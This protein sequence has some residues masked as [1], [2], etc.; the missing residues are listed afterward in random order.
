MRAFVTFNHL[1]SHPLPED[2]AELRA[3]IQ[4]LRD[5]MN[6]ILADQNDLVPFWKISYIS[7]KNRYCNLLSR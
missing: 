5:Q 3:E 1:T 6:D 7:S 4:A 2:N